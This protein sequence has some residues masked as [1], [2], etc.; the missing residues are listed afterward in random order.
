MVHLPVDC[1]V[2]LPN[3]RYLEVLQTSVTEALVKGRYTLVTLPCTVTPCR[4][5]VD[6]TREVG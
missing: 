5:S 4:D 2:P 3:L 6:G 1:S